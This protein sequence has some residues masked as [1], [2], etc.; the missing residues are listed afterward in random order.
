MLDTSNC[1]NEPI[2]FPGAVQPHGVLLALH[3]A[4]RTIQATSET[5]QAHLGL[6]ATS[7]LGQTAAQVFGEA[8]DQA[9]LNAQGDGLGTVV[10]LALGARRLQARVSVNE[11][12]LVLLDLEPAS[13]EGRVTHMQ[14]TLRNQLSVL[15]GM[16]TLPEVTEA[17]ARLMRQVTGFDRVMVYR[18]DE[19]WNGEVV[20]EARDPAIEPYLG[21]HFPA[22]DIPA[23]ARALFQ[24]SRVR[25]IADTRYT[26]S[27]LITPG[28]AH[29]VDLGSSGLRSVSPIHLE[30]LANMQVRATLVGSLVVDGRLWG[31]VS[32]QHKHEPM[33]F[34]PQARDV[35][36]W[37]CD[38]VAVL[39]QS[40][41][42]RQRRDS[43]ASLS[44]RRRRL[45]ERIRAAP[46]KTLIRQGDNAELLGVVGAD[47]FALIADGSVQTTGQ[48]PT[49]AR[50]LVLQGQRPA[51]Q[52]DAPACVSSA[53]CQD[54]GLDDVG[55]GVAGAIFVSL[56][57]RPDVALIWFR[58][59]YR[60]NVRWGGD[61]AHAHVADATGR[62]S[63]RKSFEQFLQGV[64]GQ[65]LRWTAE[66]IESATELA[67]LI[68]IEA[69]REERSRLRITFEAM[70]E[71][72]VF[73][74]ADSQIVDANPAAAQILGLS[75]D[76]L[77]G[78]TSI[79]PRWYTVGE[80]GG[81]LPG[82]RHPPMV[83]LRTGAALREQTL[84]VQAPNFGLRW[85]SV[86]S[87]PV[88]DVD[89]QRPTAA[90]TTF[91]D[92]T[93]R[94][95]LAAALTASEMELSDLYN[96]APC[97]YHSLDAQGRFL[98][99]NDTA[100]AWLGRRREDVVGHLTARDIFT[101]EGQALFEQS[102][103]KLLAEGHVDGL[104][105]DLV[106]E[107]RPLRRVSVSA[108]AVRDA[109]D[110][111]VCSR[112]V[113]YDITDL[114]QAQA[115][116]RRLTQEQ[117]AMLD[118]ELVGIVKMQDRCILWSN[119]AADQMLGY[120]PG[121]LIG[122][123][124]RPFYPTDAAYESFGL[125]AF[126]LLA[127][128]KGFS[129]R[130]TF[131]RKDGQHIWVDVNGAA[132]NASGVSLWVLVDVTA[133]KQ[134][135]DELEK[136]RKSLEAMVVE[137][138]AEL[139][140]ALEL[141]RAANQAKS[142]FLAMMSHELRT[143]MNAILGFTPIVKRRITDPKCQDYLSMV[144]VA[145]QQLL[146]L[147]D[148]VLEVTSIEANR[149]QI[150]SGPLQLADIM[151]RVDAALGPKIVHKGLRLQI[152]SPPALL[153]KRFNGDALRIEQIL[154]NLVG[155]AIKFTEHG[156][157]RIGLSATP[158]ADERT[159]LLIEVTDTGIGIAEA[160]QAR[161][162]SLFEQVDSSLTRPHGGSGLGL[163]LCAK[164][165]PL[166]GG[167]IGVRSVLGQG[168]CFW[169]ALPLQ[170]GWSVEG[171]VPADDDAPGRLRAGFAGR[172]VLVVEDNIVNAEVTRLLLEDVDLAVDW[173]SG[174]TMALEQVAARP[175]DLI[176]MDLQM[177]VM[178]GLTATRAIRAMP[179]G[180]GI[181]IV[182]LTARVLDLDRAACTD[183]GIDDVIAKPVV[184]PHF[185]RRVLVALT[186]SGRTIE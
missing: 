38:D 7:L 70:S 45:F 44:E 94:R 162:F 64:Q 123:P 82:D 89:P 136:H 99:I 138:T 130:T 107:G 161:V 133:R 21:L 79:D 58:R 63:P 96:R 33:H 18:F 74:S 113:M 57:D 53:L 106:S 36:G 17:A 69:L 137:R 68:D 164:L 62:L 85:L 28:D 105:F 61:P 13:D 72:L 155:N 10:A 5:C 145:G 147:I 150:R 149:L 146:A 20:A 42:A 83:T 95:R 93:E 1:E 139:T 120:A 108:T 32:C 142:A 148:D 84:G 67:G 37:F 179:H 101:P 46:I 88:F 173:A 19:A 12:G 174:G 81:P 144:E 135:E 76:Q 115:E 56:R 51:R 183:A 159:Q 171:T 90:V 54:L 98:R 158:R 50:I 22:S 43:E 26:P 178:D 15:R 134:A 151:A 65:C 182:A 168:S 112:T 73:Q 41:Q 16:T 122:L 140:T 114:H 103:P 11:A 184:A 92:V 25:M 175:Y 39:I 9:L 102:F 156:S 186:K 167:R 87:M 31:L 30:Y 180:Q 91:V 8:A 127:Q 152:E 170:D 141:A 181:P 55:D 128:G 163:A 125:Q 48:T 6:S 100:L 97:G 176:I 166:M 177:P 172:R 126:P 29:A 75:R 132:F 24:R 80:D 23:Q 59:E 27:A 143:P 14:Y 66:E 40:T 169:L 185:Y 52:T 121:E 157:I 86:N 111:F 109:D 110:R 117:R 3:P 60:F 49:P 104:E 154:T 160:D 4:S 165:A 118:N 78:R 119:R 116:L 131:V 124:G 71:G 2:R 35:L 34:G 47:G 129:L 77:L 153:T